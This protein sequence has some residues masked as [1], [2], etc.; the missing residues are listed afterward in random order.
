ML[1][2][3]PLFLLLAFS[4]SLFPLP[5]IQQASLSPQLHAGACARHQRYQGQPCPRGQALIR[6]VGQKSQWCCKHDSRRVRPNQGPLFFPLYSAP[7]AS[8]S[9]P[10]GLSA[11][12]V[13]N[14]PPPRHR[15]G[16]LPHL[17]EVTAHLSQG[18]PYPLPG[19]A[20]PLPLSML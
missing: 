12:R 19:P 16:S 15:S 20:R 2:S 10:A 1:I 8:Q 11:P 14:V 9:A 13:W 17:F 18:L 7:Q 6:K 3:I 4:S 5:F